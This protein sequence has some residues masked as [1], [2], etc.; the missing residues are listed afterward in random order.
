MRC[1]VASASAA[2]SGIGDDAGDEALFLRFGRTED[3][4]FE[5]DLE[6]N[7]GAGRGARAEPFPDRP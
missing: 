3:S 6:R 5:Q 7:V 4:A 2:Y 1:A